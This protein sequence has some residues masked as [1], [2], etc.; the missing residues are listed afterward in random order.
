MNC[1]EV[2]IA[3]LRQC[4]KEDQ[5]YFNILMD[6]LKIN[7]YLKRNCKYIKILKID[8]TDSLYTFNDMIGYLINAINDQEVSINYDIEKRREKISLKIYIDN[9]Y[10][11]KND[12]LN[13]IG[14]I[15]RVIKDNY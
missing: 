8:F 4:Y 13:L 7:Y 10:M 1:K 5:E 11:I 12:K 3:R 2:L 6:C 14:D 15:A 9:N